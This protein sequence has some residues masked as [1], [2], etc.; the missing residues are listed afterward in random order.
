MF[1]SNNC[2]ICQN[3]FVKPV[4]IPCGHVFCFKCLFKWYSI[5]SYVDGNNFK[6]SPC[7][8]CR[9]VFYDKHIKPCNINIYK[10]RL[11]QSRYLY[12][13]NSKIPSISHVPF[14]TRNQT[15]NDRW[16]KTMKHLHDICFT[17]NNNSVWEVG[18][19]EKI[20]EFLKYIH[21]NNWFIQKYGWGNSDSEEI[22]RKAF[23]KLL[24]TKLHQ[25]RDN[26]VI[27][28]N[29][30][31]FKYRKFLYNIDYSY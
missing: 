9:R 1:Y 15:H 8:I 28:S 26:G 7:P 23:I 20:V 16:R 14:R 30:F 4:T 10:N 2:T 18:S 24:T 29:Y 17:H 3:K 11:F 12:T 25:W 21:N 5:S 19:K 6:V 27:Y 31:I 22:Q 13:K